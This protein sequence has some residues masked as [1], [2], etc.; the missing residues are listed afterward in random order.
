MEDK[1]NK[2]P[3]LGKGKLNNGNPAH[4][5]TVEEQREGAKKSAEARRKKKTMREQLITMLSLEISDNHIQTKNALREMG[6]DDENLINQ[7]A[8]LLGQISKAIRG[9]TRAAEFVR[10]TMGEKP[11]NTSNINIDPDNFF[12]KTNIHFDVVADREKKSD[13]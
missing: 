3:E 4:R 7:S 9:D 12:Q 8:I 2:E 11:E 1:S 13:E 5:L 6:V 10:D